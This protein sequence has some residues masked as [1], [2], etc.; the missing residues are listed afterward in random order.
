MQTACLEILPPNLICFF[1][2]GSRTLCC[3]SYRT[4]FLARP[5]FAIVT[6]PLLETMEGSMLLIEA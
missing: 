2:D 4:A 6:A 1:F 3:R 5:A